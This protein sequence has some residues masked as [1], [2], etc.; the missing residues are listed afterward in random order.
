MQLNRLGESIKNNFGTE[1]KIIEYNS[2]DDMVVEFQD[3]YKY[4][5]KTIYQNFKLGQIKNPY[6]KIR[7]GVGYIG[8][9]KHKVEEIR[10]THNRYYDTW[11]NMLERCYSEK[12]RNKHPAYINYTVCDEWHNFQTFAEWYIENYY[13]IGKGRM[14]LDKDIINPGNTVYCP[15]YC[16]F[17]PQRINLLFVNKGKTNNKDLPL[18][19]TLTSSNKFQSSYD[20]V[21][22]GTYTELEE[23]VAAHR[24]AKKQKIKEVAEEY[25]S[26]IPQRL[27]DALIN[28][29][30]K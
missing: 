24:R 29:D 19:V 30:E 12:L 6:D 16:I 17:V 2:T 15:D 21:Y 13:D 3:S 4:R 28:W 14:H 8:V 1:M 5:V 27:Y 26:K 23:A 18:G 9:G 22:I 7:Y 11:Q 20:G 25:K 10:G